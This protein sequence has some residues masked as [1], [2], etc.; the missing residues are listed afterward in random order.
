MTRA[1]CCGLNGSGSDTPAASA[2][3]SGYSDAGLRDQC[4]MVKGQ[5]CQPRSL[6]RES[7]G[8]LFTPGAGRNPY[9]VRLVPML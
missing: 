5:G 8:D 7:G 4:L 6:R 1:V 2:P 3:L 9:P